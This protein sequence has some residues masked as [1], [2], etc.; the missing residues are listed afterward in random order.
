MS[1]KA[2]NTASKPKIIRRLIGG[3][4]DFVWLIGAILAAFLLFPAQT[5]HCAENGQIIMDL[6]PPAI[7]IMHPL[8]G[9][10]LEEDRPWIEAYVI[11]ADSEIKEDAIFISLDG[12]DISRAAI[13]T[14]IEDG[15]AEIGKGWLIRYRPPLPLTVGRH[16]VQIDVADIAGN[17]NREQWYFFI[18]TAK[19][20]ADW[21]VS[22]TNNLSYSFLPLRRFKDVANLSLNFQLPGHRVILQAQG[23][24][25]DYPGRITQ[26][27]L[28]KLYVYPDS[29]AVSWQTKWFE[30]QYG[31]ISLPFDFGLLQF[32]LGFKGSR[33]HGTIGQGHRWEIFKGISVNSMG[34]GISLLD[35]LGAVYGWQNRGSQIEGYT[36]G[37]KART[38]MT[39]A[40]G[41]RY[42]QVFPAG[43][44]QSEV[45]YALGDTGGGG[46]RLQGASEFASFFWNGDFIFI[47]DSN[48]LASLTP[49]S[50]N[51][52]GVYRYAINCDKM[53]FTDTQ[54]NLGYSQMT[55]NVSG[56]AARTTKNKSWQAGLSGFFKP[57]FSWQLGYS[58][59][60][61]ESTTISLQHVFRATLRQKLADNSWNGNMSISSHSANNTVKYL[62][63]A[64]YTHPFPALGLSTSASLQLTLEDKREAELVR[65]IRLRVSGNK[66][67]LD[68]LLNSSLILE[69]LNDRHIR[70]SDSIYKR[71]V[72]RLQGS[73]DFKAG[74]RNSFRINGKVSSWQNRRPELTR[75]VDF[76]LD[77]LWRLRIF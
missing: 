42:N 67:W 20:K 57:D 23:S 39:G 32:G 47:Q 49:L 24:L 14:M 11:D 76:G 2:K 66:D 18:E 60:K 44:L 28:G 53:I 36:L 64:G 71:N 26:P 46:I 34:M 56:K 22:L 12:I 72:L 15:E 73:L 59:G 48:P 63:N 69:L 61:R 9:A 68:D 31:N 43:I 51:E 13:F 75:G 27:N 33:L 65:G 62:L 21:G 35:T 4:I 8:A 17:T 54:I 40:F 1:V 5:A 52:G 16:I 50:N 29:Y 38:G 45:L 25:T 77:F 74:E 19:P 30:F 41:L 10:K 7:I 6:E 70:P 58:G 3:K 55:N 37:L